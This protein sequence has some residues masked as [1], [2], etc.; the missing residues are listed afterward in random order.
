MPKNVLAISVFM[1]QEGDPPSFP[2]TCDVV[3]VAAVWPRV[4]RLGAADLPDSST[5]PPPTR[6]LMTR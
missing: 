4:G 2:V 5:R 6:Q 1:V 3:R